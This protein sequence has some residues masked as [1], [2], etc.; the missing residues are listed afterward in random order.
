MEDAHLVDAPTITP[1]WDCTWNYILLYI[2]ILLVFGM[3][4]SLLAGWFCCIIEHLQLNWLQKTLWL[5]KY[6]ELDEWFDIW[7]YTLWTW[8]TLQ[9]W[10]WYIMFKKDVWRIIMMP[11]RHLQWWMSLYKSFHV[12]C[13]CMNLWLKTED[14][15]LKRVFFLGCRSCD[16]I[17]RSHPL[18]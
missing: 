5:Y 7:V 4:L 9:K 12:V 6:I 1:T 15:I 3:S 16:L 2:D 8:R 14:M 17:T 13:I 10:R 11:P 18:G